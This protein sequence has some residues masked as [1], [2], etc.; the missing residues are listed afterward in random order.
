MLERSNQSTSERQLTRGNGLRLRMG[1]AVTALLLLLLGAV[2]GSMLVQQSARAQDGGLLQGMLQRAAIR[3]ATGRLARATSAW[4]VRSALTSTRWG[5]LQIGV[6]WT[7]MPIYFGLCFA[8]ARLGPVP[9]SPTGFFAEFFATLSAAFFA[10]KLVRE[11]V[12]LP[13]LRL[14][15]QPS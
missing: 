1:I 13:A 4:E 9:T 3:D 11:I 8:V 6:L 15:E 5:R 14:L 12:T 10:E 2:G 7:M